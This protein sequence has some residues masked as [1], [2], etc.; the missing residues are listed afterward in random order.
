MLFRSPHE[1]PALPC[2][3]DG[4][5]EPKDLPHRIRA[6]EQHHRLVRPEGP[7]RDRVAEALVHAPQERGRP[8]GPSDRL[9]GGGGTR[10]GRKLPD[11]AWK[12]SMP[13]LARTASPGS[14][15]IWSESKSCFADA[16]WSA[17]PLR[18][19]TD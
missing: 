17:D 14:A 6:G 9:P 12:V 2:R 15:S 13:P 8:H 11:Q 5:V 3:G 18:P 1:L 7:D 19:E 4:R 10:A 16:I